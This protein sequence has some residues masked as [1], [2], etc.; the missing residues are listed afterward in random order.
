MKYLTT[1]CGFI[2]AFLCL[3]QSANAQYL[4]TQIH[5]DK[6]TFV[7]E[8]GRTLSDAELIDAIGIDVFEETVVGARKQYTAGRKLVVSGAAGLGVGLVGTLAGAAMFAAAKPEETDDGRVHVENE[9]LAMTGCI[10]LAIG[11]V[12]ATL[13]GTALAVG[14]PLKAVGQSRLNWVEN[15]YNERS[16]GVTARFGATHNGVGLTLSF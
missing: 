6:A 1:L 10:T 16:R 5:R 12:A 7:D 8:H 14:I 3:A 4:P 9:D 2:A 15:D 11:V 13:G